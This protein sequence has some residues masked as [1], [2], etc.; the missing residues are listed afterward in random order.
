MKSYDTG[1]RRS[2]IPPELDGYLD[3][4]KHKSSVFG[5]WNKRYFRVN[6]N[7][8]CLEYFSNKPANTS[9][10]ANASIK[11]SDLKVI[12]KFDSNSFQ[13]DAGVSGVYLLR[14]DSQAQFTCWFNGLDR[15]IKDKK[16]C[17]RVNEAYNATQKEIFE[18]NHSRK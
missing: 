4:L 5:S 7:N 3:K 12:R 13:L 14:T 18:I 2:P 9:V 17:E 6:I 1:I 8:E 10:T 16:E 11:L 15:Y